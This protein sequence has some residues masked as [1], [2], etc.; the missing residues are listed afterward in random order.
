MIPTKIQGVNRLAETKAGFIY[1]QEVEKDSPKKI[2]FL[3]LLSYTRDQFSKIILEAPL[4]S[5]KWTRNKYA[6][7][8]RING[9]QNFPNQLLKIDEHG[10]SLLKLSSQLQFEPKIELLDNE[11]NDDVR[12]RLSA[13][14]GELSYGSVNHQ[15]DYVEESSIKYPFPMSIDEY[16]AVSDDGTRVPCSLTK[17][18]ESFGPLPAVVKVYGSY[19]SILRPTIGALEGA[20]LANNIAFVFAHA[21]GG[22]E[23]GDKWAKGGRGINKIKTIQDTEACIATAIKQK[24]I[25]SGRILMQGESAGGIPAMM[26]ALR[27]PDKIQGAWLDVPY[28]DSSGLHHNS[29]ADDTEFGK[30]DDMTES[31]ARLAISPYQRLL[32]PDKSSGSF[33]LTCGSQDARVPAWHCM[34]AHMAI[35]YFHPNMQSHLFVSENSAHFS[36]KPGSSEGKKLDFLILDFMLKTLKTE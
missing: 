36:Y 27:N 33:L 5:I 26:V 23:L 34:K 20:V 28:L 18:A 7:I 9:D 4:D 29:S 19:G 11:R 6:A 24:K 14:T 16:F 21:R 15:G 2:R 12:I 17:K 3:Q 30:V 25:L 32:V 13:R 31:L 10:I 35:K 8:V 22:G 1:A